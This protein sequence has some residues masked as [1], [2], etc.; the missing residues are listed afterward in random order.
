MI[1]PFL[2][3][4][5]RGIHTKSKHSPLPRAVL[6]QGEIYAHSLYHKKVR[7]CTTNFRFFKK[8]GK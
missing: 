7:F 3:G 5:G 1:Y 6:T 4:D 8:D 2:P